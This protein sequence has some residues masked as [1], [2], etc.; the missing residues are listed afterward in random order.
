[1]AS[2]K[3]RTRRPGPGRPPKDRKVA[4]VEVK[5]LQS[6]VPSKFEATHANSPYDFIVVLPCIDGAIK[7]VSGA[8]S[9]KALTVHAVNFVVVVGSGG[10]LLNMHELVKGE[11]RLGRKS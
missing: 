7:A 8:F 5:G 10:L 3:P 9:S 2:E 4:S 6:N 1:M 11:E